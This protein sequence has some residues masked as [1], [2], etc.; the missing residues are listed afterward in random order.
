[1]ESSVRRYRAFVCT[2]E[3]GPLGRDS[4]SLGM[5]SSTSGCAHMRHMHKPWVQKHV[6][7]APSHG[8]FM[9]GQ[10]HT[11]KLAQCMAADR[12]G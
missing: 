8:C 12:N 10:I 2:Q 7:C 3:T 4:A 11:V 9:L 1:M 6:C 5:R